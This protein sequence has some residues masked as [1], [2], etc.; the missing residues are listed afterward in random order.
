M[1]A[2]GPPV[3]LQPEEAILAPFRAGSCSLQEYAAGGQCDGLVAARRLTM[4]PA[5]AN[6]RGGSDGHRHVFD[7][8]LRPL[9]STAVSVNT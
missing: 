8:E 2:A 3:W 9:L 7:D 6:G 5:V 4:G 1:V